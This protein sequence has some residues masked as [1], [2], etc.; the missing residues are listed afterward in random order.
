MIE[1]CVDRIFINNFFENLVDGMVEKLTDANF[2]NP[3][4]RKQIIFG[5]SVG[6]FLKILWVGIFGKFKK[7][8]RAKLAI[9]ASKL[10]PRCSFLGFLN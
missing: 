5:N 6:G 3:A 8:Q 1:N 10:K 9:L 2:E 4:D 7:D